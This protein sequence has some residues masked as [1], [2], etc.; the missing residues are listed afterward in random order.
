[1]WI[2]DSGLKTPGS[3]QPFKMRRVYRFLLL[4][5]LALYL[6]LYLSSPKIPTQQSIALAQT[7]QA[8]IEIL[9]ARL[10]SL[11]STVD[12]QKL[13]LTIETS[14]QD[15][16]LTLA[17]QIQALEQQFTNWNEKRSQVIRS[18]DQKEAQVNR[19]QKETIRHDPYSFPGHPD[20]YTYPHPHQDQSRPGSGCSGSAGERPHWTRNELRNYRQRSGRGPAGRHRGRIGRMVQILLCERRQTRVV[21]QQLGNDIA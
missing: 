21:A 1:M 16:I 9:Q 15:W 4:T 5:A 12:W 7:T 3:R 2:L 14:S 17:T 20:V 10:L 11:T 6:T 8:N 13:W 18:L 19:D